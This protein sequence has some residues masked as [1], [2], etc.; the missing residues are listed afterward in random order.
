MRKIA[1][2]I[3]VVSVFCS[4]VD[5]NPIIFARK[6]DM[7]EVK[8]SLDTN[9]TFIY[10]AQSTVGTPFHEEGTYTVE[11]TLLILRFE[12]ESY[13]YNTYEI[14]LQNDTMLIM[15][16]KGENVLFPLRREF[17]EQNIH[18]SQKEMMENIVEIYSSSDFPKYVGTRY[19]SH[20][21]GDFS[22]IYKGDYKI[23]PYYDKK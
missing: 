23:S 12:F 19:F 16:Y 15:S 22:F 3:F 14:P 11:D 7:S 18:L 5:K 17:P 13:T 20:S 21:S 2:F 9:G 4:C 6:T 10:T 8:L 1:L